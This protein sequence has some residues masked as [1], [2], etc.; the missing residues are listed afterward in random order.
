[1]SAQDN[2][3]VHELDPLMAVGWNLRQSEVAGL[4]QQIAK[5]K[6]AVE[7]QKLSIGAGQAEAEAHRKIVTLL[8]EWRQDRDD[9]NC[10]IAN[11]DHWRDVFIALDELDKAQKSAEPTRANQP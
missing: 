8:R 9:G 7:W 6:S 3:P 5:L 1:M 11:C 2:G 4:Q 10:W